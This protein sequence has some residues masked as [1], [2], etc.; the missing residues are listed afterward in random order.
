MPV[1]VRNNSIVAV[2]AFCY[3][4]LRSPPRF[5]VWWHFSSLFEWS[6]I[7][8]FMVWNHML[9]LS[10]IY[11]SY[12]LK[13]IVVSQIIVYAFSFSGLIGVMR[14][15][16]VCYETLLSTSLVSVI[17]AATSVTFY[18]MHVFVAL[19]RLSLPNSIQL[20]AQYPNRKLIQR[21]RVLRFLGMPK[22]FM[23]GW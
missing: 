11:C 17:N 8:D 4:R 23:D 18:L 20:W 5:L 13:L 2:I 7:V 16:E 1:S 14:K 22:K 12:K 10:S 15:L 19:Y 6:W 9:A 3:T 21:W